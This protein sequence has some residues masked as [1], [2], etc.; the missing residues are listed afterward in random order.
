MKNQ[1][2]TSDQ[3][4]TETHR[5][6]ITVVGNIIYYPGEV[7]MHTPDSTTMKQHVNSAIFDIKF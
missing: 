1:Y 3:K 2:V 4:K 6:R 7:S 5:T